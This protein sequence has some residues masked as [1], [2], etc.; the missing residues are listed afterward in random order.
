M[1][2]LHHLERS[3]TRYRLAPPRPARGIGERRRRDPAAGCRSVPVKILLTGKNGQIGWELA[4]ALAPLGEVVAFDSGG[5]DLAVPDQIVGAVRSVRPHV[6]VNAPTYTPVDPA[7][8][9]PDATHAVKPAALA[10]LAEERKQ[11]HARVIH[12]SPDR[13]IQRSKYA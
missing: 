7:E 9:E 8:T 10:I 2:A 11:L 6:L 13:V 5:L 1:R 12:F 4:H 3:G